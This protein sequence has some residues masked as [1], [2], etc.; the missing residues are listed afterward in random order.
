MTYKFSNKNSK[1]IFLLLFAAYTVSYIG[2][3]TYG[4]CM[5][6]I[7][8]SLA[9]DSLFAGYISTGY[10]FCYGL[11]QII[12]GFLADKVNPSKMIG[13][14]LCGA[15][16][17]N[18]LAGLS[19][20]PWHLLIFWCLN[21]SCQSMLW[22]STIRSI[23][24]WLPKEDHG[25]AGT[26]IGAT[27]PIGTL[28]AYLISSL[29]LKY[30]NWR[31][32]FIFA[33]VCV[34][35]MGIVWFLGCNRKSAY[36]NSVSVIETEK[37]KESGNTFES[38]IYCVI[39]CGTV[40]VIFALFCNGILKDG[41]TDWISSFL[42]ET[43]G[44]T[45]SNSALLLTLLPITNLTGNY[46]ARWFDQKYTHN[47]IAC[48]CILFTLS[49][50]FIVLIFFSK[51]AIISAILFAMVCALMGG[52]NNE[53][54]TFVPLH[55]SKIGKSGLITGFFNS[56]SYLAAALSGIIAG[57]ILQTKTWMYLI[58][59]W[60]IISAVGI[61]VCLIGAKQWDRGKLILEENV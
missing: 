39:T 47:E 25:I 59:F 15:G 46:V 10:L 16:F 12:S 28:I 58:A 4:A 31:F 49:S 45:A 41:M 17:F 30:L 38:L 20:K 13:F 52:I 34:F 22:S 5:S 23:S 35:F 19:L 50:T 44:T 60:G 33:G 42:S 7:K 40:S 56:C 48:S 9:F 61:P 55:F 14:G 2:R 18:I 54:L 11:G 29:C 37:I 1:T 32:A 57:G 51:S 53:L 27:L 36:I 26:N 6:D 8:L 21:G 24:L 43:Y 3:K